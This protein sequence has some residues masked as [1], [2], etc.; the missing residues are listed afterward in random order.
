VARPG[1]DEYVTPAEIAARL[2]V[3][4]ATVYAL[5]ERGDLTASRIGLSLRVK[6]RDLT[7]FLERIGG[8]A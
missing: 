1:G 4:R 6:E 2:K 8:M 3:S 7:V 5:I